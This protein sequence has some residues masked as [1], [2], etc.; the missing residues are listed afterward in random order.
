V[1]LA[2]SDPAI[3]DPAISDPAI[4]G[5]VNVA[6]MIAACPRV[7]V[8]MVRLPDVLEG[9]IQKATDIGV[10]GV[11]GPTV[12]TVEQATALANFARFPPEGHRS[13]GRN[14]AARIWGGNGINYRQSINDNMLV[15][16]Q[17]ETPI[18]VENAYHIARVSGIDVLWASNGDLGNFSG[19]STTSPEWH[20]MFD[21]VKE[22]TL[23]AG[24]FVG[25]TNVGY[26]FTGPNGRPDAADW[27]FFYNGPS[28]DGYQPRRRQGS[29]TRLR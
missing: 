5:T 15:V 19:L 7:G 29:A 13:A 28:M 10:L 16:A 3:S 23:S 9:S 12:N 26:A 17:I 18:A 6:A 21:K 11:I 24:K 14:R 4:S 2:I 1:V 22:A 8:P 27:R 25:S 20:A